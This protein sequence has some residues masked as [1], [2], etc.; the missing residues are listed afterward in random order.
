MQIKTLL[1]GLAL[2]LVIAGPTSAEADWLFTP[3][4]GGNVGGDTVKTQPNFGV[5]A[6]WMGAK[7]VGVEFDASWAKDF[8]TTGNEA[9]A[10]LVSGSRVSTYMVNGIFGIPVG[11]QS[12]ASVRPYVSAGL[13]AIQTRVESDLGLVDIDRTDLG[14]NVG[15]GAIGFLNKTVGVRGDARFLQS[16]ESG[17]DG[18]DTNPLTMDAGKSSFWRLSAGVVLR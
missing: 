4:A 7:V 8:F 5:S 1:S 2:A 11:D 17:T 9:A 18:S 3:Y 6:A 14:W 13:G 16:L 12:G 10:P 15:A